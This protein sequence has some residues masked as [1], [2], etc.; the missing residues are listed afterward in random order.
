MYT[1]FRKCMI[2]TSQSQTSRMS[3]MG[4]NKKHHKMYTG[5]SQQQFEFSFISFALRRV[6]T[7]RDI[8]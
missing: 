7:M 8:D 4:L 3:Q 5:H 1:T 6:Q 2:D